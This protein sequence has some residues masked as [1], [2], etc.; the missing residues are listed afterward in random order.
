[1]GKGN[2][3]NAPYLEA[4]LR[5]I[6]PWK[7]QGLPVTERWLQATLHERID[8]IDWVAMRADIQKLVRDEER[9]P[10]EGWTP[11][12]FHG[13]TRH[14]EG[15]GF[16]RKPPG[17]KYLPDDGG[18]PGRKGSARRQW[19]VSKDIARGARSTSKT[20]TQIAIASRSG[21]HGSMAFRRNG[22]IA[23]SAGG[24]SSTVAKPA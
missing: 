11:E 20:S 3:I 6:G 24:G 10:V 5:Q 23:T 18:S 9:S 19:T 2:P 22:F 14:P 4:T 8:R 17:K 16:L 12:T 7:V 21:L 15:Q 13:A 1:M